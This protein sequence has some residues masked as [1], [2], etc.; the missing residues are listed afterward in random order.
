MGSRTAQ[1][2]AGREVELR[3]RSGRDGCP[4]RCHG[5]G[6]TVEEVG[7]ERALT[8]S[9]SRRLFHL[10][11]FHGVLLRCFRYFHPCFPSCFSRRLSLLAI[12]FVFPSSLTSPSLPPC[13]FHCFFSPCYSLCFPFLL[14]SPSSPPNYF[15]CLAILAIF[16][17]FLF[18]LFPPPPFFAILTVFLSL[19]VSPCFLRCHS[20]RLSLYA[21]FIVFPSLLFFL[22]FL[23]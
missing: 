4:G 7:I 10:C 12:L 6:H 23:S 15:H 20:R 2:M 19:I 11:S 3:R 8:S 5:T 18:L 22:F 13:Y 14:F 9:F 16:T 17:V 1:G 21:S